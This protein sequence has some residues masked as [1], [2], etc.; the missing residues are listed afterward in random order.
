MQ[1]ITA[2]AGDF[3]K[4]SQRKDENAGSVAVSNDRRVAP[5]AILQPGQR[6]QIWLAFDIRSGFG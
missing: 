4:F 5:V 1:F 3:R 2:D 6:E